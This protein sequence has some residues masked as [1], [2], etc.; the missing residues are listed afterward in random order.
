MS[1]QTLTVHILRIFFICEGKSL[2]A[3][4]LNN[5][6]LSYESVTALVVDRVLGYKFRDL[7]KKLG[8]WDHQKQQGGLPKNH[9]QQAAQKY[10]FGCTRW[11]WDNQ[12]LFVEWKDM[13]EVL[14]CSSRPMEMRPSRGG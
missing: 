4:S 2:V 9:Q 8:L 1:L 14:L 6:G 5:E 11:I 3:Q 10:T 12:L 13:R 7:E